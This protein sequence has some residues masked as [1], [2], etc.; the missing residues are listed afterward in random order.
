MSKKHKAAAKQR[1]DD[2]RHLTAAESLAAQH[3]ADAR[4]AAI[5]SGPPLDDD[6]WQPNHTIMVDGHA[7]ACW[8]PPGV[9]LD[10]DAGSGP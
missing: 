8:L 9:S 7:M 1:R 4:V 6:D 3:D 2:E 5:E 10:A